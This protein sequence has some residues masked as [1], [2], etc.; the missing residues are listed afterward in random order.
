MLKLFPSVPKQP[1]VATQDRATDAMTAAEKRVAF[2]LAAIFALR[3]LGLFMI[4]PV[5]S[6]YAEHYQGYTPT[7][8]GL[9]IGIYGLTQAIFQIPFG[10]L[11]DRVGRKPIIIGGLLLFAVGSVIA[12]FADSMLGLIIGRGLQ[13]MGAIAAVVMALAA[14]LTREEQRTKA[15]AIIGASIGIA[16]TAAL[17]LGPVLTHWI[18]LSGVFALTALLALGGI[19]LL[20]HAV[21]KPVI[22]RH[23]RDA[24]TLPSQIRRVVRDRQLLRLDAGILI[25]HGILTASFVV[26][27]LL[28]RDYGQLEA[29]QHWLVYLSVLLASVCLMTPFILIADKYRLTKPIFA[30]AVLM[31][32]LAQLG[33]LTFHTTLWQIALLLVVFFTGFNILEANLPS[34]I[35]RLAPPEAKGTALGIYSTSQ[36]LGAFIGG[37]GGGWLYAH[38]GAVA[39]FEACAA[40]ALIWFALALTM[41][42]PQ[43]LSSH[44][45]RLM[46]ISENEAPGVAAKLLAIPG[47]AEAV[48]IAEE[49]VAYLKVDRKRLDRQA[50]QAISAVEA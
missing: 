5:L 11:S 7:L 9:A 34:L 41:K 48:V 39:V 14:D 38:Y 1:A 46:P 50:L 8:A 45:V 43:A 30:A 27:P 17:I 37:L 21:P 44:L 4:L 31:L 18:G 32:A 26:I 3:M 19:L 47:V 10:I 42:N 29:S 15:M 25:L 33:L 28:L 12:A 40:L 24:E 36:F 23:H 35:S 20:Q 13:G 6:L 2:S 16:F 22:Q 49:R